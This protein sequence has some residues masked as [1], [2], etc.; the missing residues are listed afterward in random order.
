[1][2]N[3]VQIKTKYLVTSFFGDRLLATFDNVSGKNNHLIYSIFHIEVCPQIYDIIDSY[4]IVKVD[5]I[6][7][8]SSHPSIHLI[9]MLPMP[10]YTNKKMEMM[11]KDILTRYHEID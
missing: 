2:G 6:R 5:R 8:S 7:S 10:N 11:I 1:M 4:S 9:V 3:I